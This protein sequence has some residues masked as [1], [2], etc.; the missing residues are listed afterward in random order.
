[1][2]ALVELPPQP[3]NPQLF[4]IAFHDQIRNLNLKPA[5]LRL[6]NSQLYLESLAEN[7]KPSMWPGH[8]HLPAVVRLENDLTSP[9]YQNE[10]NQLVKLGI[11]QDRVTHEIIRV[12]LQPKLLLRTELPL[13]R[14]YRGQEYMQMQ[15]HMEMLDLLED[16]QRS[17]RKRGNGPWVKLSVQEAWGK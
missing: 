3:Q 13:A 17:L 6:H 16:G 15:P 2:T 10:Q 12:C 8:L 4:Q 5:Q 7:T 14:P 1:M 11:L 9:Q